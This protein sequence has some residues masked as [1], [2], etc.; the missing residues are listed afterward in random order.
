[1]FLFEDELAIIE[2]AKEIGTC[3]RV[4]RVLSAT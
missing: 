4:R 2:S 3:R 1:M